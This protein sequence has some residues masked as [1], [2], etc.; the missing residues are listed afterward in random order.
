MNVAMAEKR[1]SDLKRTSRSYTATSAAE[2]EKI[3][4]VV[5]NSA[6][7][8]A[9]LDRE[10]NYTWVN[11]L[12][13]QGLGYEPPHLINKN[14][15]D[16]FPNKSHQAELA[17]VIKSGQEKV[18]HDVAAKL[19]F[20]EGKTITYWDITA[21]PV[22][23]KRKRVSGL[24]L[25]VIDTSKYKNSQFMLE[26]IAREWR[27]TFDCIPDFV[28]IHDLNYKMIR[29]NRALADALKLSPQDM[30]GKK[31]YALFHKTE[32]P[33]PSC[34]HQKALYSGE[35]VHG[36]IY[37]PAFGRYLEV[38]VTPLL[39]KN[40]KIIGT[41]HIGRNI[42]E[43][44]IAEKAFRNQEERL[45]LAL[46]ATRDGVW[47]WE[48]ETGTVWCSPR[49]EEML[50]Y[51][52]NEIEP[53]V[54]L[55]R[56]LVHTDDLAGVRQKLS[57]IHQGECE[58]KM[59]YR[60]KHKDGHYLNILSRG[61]LVRREPDGKII[62]IAGAFS[63]VTEQT[64]AEQQ[65]LKAYENEVELRQ[66][67]EDEIN[68]RIHFSHAL[69]HELKTPLSPILT[70]SGIL[71]TRLKKGNL[72]RL[73]RNINHGAL[74]LN[75]RID[76]L[77]EL[78]RIEVGTLK[79][80]LESDIDVR[81][82]VKD[83]IS[84]MKPQAASKKQKL[85]HALPEFL[86]GVA[87][88]PGRLRQILMNLIDNAL[89]YSPPGSQIR[90]SV[91][92]KTGEIIFAVRDDGPGISLEDQQFLFKPYSKIARHPDKIGGLGLGLYIS[93]HLAE[94]HEG[95]MWF[96]TES[97]KGSTFYFSIPVHFREKEGPI[98]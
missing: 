59:V 72:A 62:R 71:V 63:D 55:W 20:Q 52:Q 38:V 23:D 91:K 46:R 89:K 42:T 15:F 45:N 78:T 21:L 65:L 1:A 76:E 48:A 5:E 22:K 2:L 68:K 32:G 35:T 70:S 93:R 41:I 83:I 60:L 33:L 69:V 39:D 44:K 64:N 3:K 50:G 86:P 6:D 47:D 19:P 37:E 28:S 73:A 29:V 54:N 67:L 82:I 95:R 17:E 14:H 85:S 75:N 56:S 27:T 31:C 57:E 34:P 43:R 84:Y 87:A 92:R 11:R 77:L 58:F 13:A 49:I 40:G 4:A 80:N 9:L 98:K 7:R 79:L 61:F 10:F 30:I 18:F 25:T 36:E 16:L 24:V 51:T 53:S 97:G 94:L 12:Y 74:N 26:R 8:L 66:K 88:D 81:P 96:K 90:V